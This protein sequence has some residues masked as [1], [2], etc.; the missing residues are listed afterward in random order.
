MLDYWIGT[1][2]WGN[3]SWQ[4]VGSSMVY[5]VLETVFG[6]DDRYCLDVVSSGMALLVSFV[7]VGTLEG[8]YMVERIE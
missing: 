4:L 6:V 2:G 8:S 1:L 5:I 3:D 7:V